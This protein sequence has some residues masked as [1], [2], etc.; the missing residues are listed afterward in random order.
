MP[1]TRQCPKSSDVIE[2]AAGDFASKTAVRL[3]KLSRDE[4]AMRL[5]A[6]KKVVERVESRAN[7]LRKI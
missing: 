2:R 6:F 7:C 1:R 3:A 5:A 4:R